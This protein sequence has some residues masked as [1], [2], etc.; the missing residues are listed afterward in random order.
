MLDAIEWILPASY[1]KR[2]YNFLK[3]TYSDLEVNLNLWLAYTFSPNFSGGS[4]TKVKNRSDEI[5]KLL[6]K[7]FTCLHRTKKGFPSI[8]TA[9]GFFRLGGTE[10]PQKTVE[11]SKKKFFFWV[12]RNPKIFSPAAGFFS[13]H[14]SDDLTKLVGQ[15]R[16][17]KTYFTL[18][19]ITYA[20]NL[21]WNCINILNSFSY[22]AFSFVN[23]NLF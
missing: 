13:K 14:W 15:K 6:G 8:L 7:F 10:K 16:G 18:P 3:V 5:E 1:Y 19:L 17:S 4:R 2:N 22:G 20:R 12:K 11:F 23:V 21:Y 9:V